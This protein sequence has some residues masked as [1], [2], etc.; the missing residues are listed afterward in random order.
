MVFDLAEAVGTDHRFNKQKRMCWKGF[1]LFLHE[2][3]SSLQVSR[4]KR[5]TPVE[6][7]QL[8]FKRRCALF[9]RNI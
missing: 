1:L 3:K 8:K 7:Q 4:E 6:K 2:T 9:G 5:A